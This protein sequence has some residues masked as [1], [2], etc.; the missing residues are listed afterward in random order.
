[1]TGALKISPCVS[2]ILRDQMTLMY[3][4]LSRTFGFATVTCDTSANEKKSV[5]HMFLMKECLRPHYFF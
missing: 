2:S 5:P 1:M 3:Q 4:Q